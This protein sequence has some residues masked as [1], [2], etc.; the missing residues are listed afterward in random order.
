MTIKSAGCDFKTYPKVNFLPC[1]LI[2]LW[3]KPPSPL[4]WII[5]SPNGSSSSSVFLESQIMAF[6][7]CTPEM[8]LHLTPNSRVFT[9]ASKNLHD[10]LFTPSLIWPPSYT[11]STL[12]KLIS[13]LLLNGTRHERASGALHLRVPSTQISVWLAPSPFSLLYSKLKTR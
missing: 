6:S 2:L 1:L 5:Q 3:Y 11:P 4:D 13:L 8:T 7:A 10:L 9:T 12:A